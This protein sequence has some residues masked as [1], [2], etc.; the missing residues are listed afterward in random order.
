MFPNNLRDVRKE[1]TGL[2]VLDLRETGEDGVSLA[3]DHSVYDSFNCSHRGIVR[4]LL[5]VAGRVVDKEAMNVSEEVG[6][7]HGLQPGWETSDN[8]PD[9]F[10]D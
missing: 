4:L 9:T 1:F 3:L 5:P 2:R 8:F 10:H 7:V 6:D